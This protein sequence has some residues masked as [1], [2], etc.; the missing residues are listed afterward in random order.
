MDSE[1][2]KI[3]SETQANKENLSRKLATIHRCSYYKSCS[4][5]VLKIED[6]S[7]EKDFPESRIDVFPSRRRATEYSSQ[8][9]Y[10]PGKHTARKVIRLFV[11]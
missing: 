7:S 3:H 11:D 6:F 2:W 1:E 10:L 4:R 8:R 5:C 9:E